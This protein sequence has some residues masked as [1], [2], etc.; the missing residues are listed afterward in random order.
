MILL[1]KA[2]LRSP[3]HLTMSAPCLPAPHFGPFV[4]WPLYLSLQLP[5]SSD[6]A[7]P[8]VP[9]PSASASLIPWNLSTVRSNS[10]LPEGRGEAESRVSTRLP[11]GRDSKTNPHKNVQFLAF[12][13]IN[14]NVTDFSA[15]SFPRS[16]A[17]ESVAD[18]KEIFKPIHCLSLT[19]IMGTARAHYSD[20]SRKLVVA[21]DI[22][23]TYSGAAYAVLDPGQVPQIQ[24]VTR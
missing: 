3:L 20:L 9:Q 17:K 5:P 16:Y 13:G 10:C 23:T 6:P 8:V 2:N 7:V 22:G 18:P 14:P 21:L 1:V 19:S 4:F 15:T 11:A 12:D 24:S